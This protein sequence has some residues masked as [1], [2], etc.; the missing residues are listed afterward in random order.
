MIIILNQ[1]E[2]WMISKKQSVIGLECHGE[3]APPSKTYLHSSH[4]FSICVGTTQ[5][6]RLTKLASTIKF[7]NTP[8][9]EEL[10]KI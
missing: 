10:T 8:E 6:N 1:H 5:L 7:E 9:T 4:V 2:R 3:N